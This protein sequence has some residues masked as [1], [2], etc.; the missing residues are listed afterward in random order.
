MGSRVMIFNMQ[1]S[2]LRYKQAGLND[3]LLLWTGTFF[4]SLLASEHDV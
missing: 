1:W 2:S 4:Y 3:N